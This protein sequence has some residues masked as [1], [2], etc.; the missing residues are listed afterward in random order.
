M[1]KILL[2]LILLFACTAIVAQGAASVDRVKNGFGTNLTACTTQQCVVIRQIA[3][4]DI[5][6]NGTFA[7]DASW[8]KG[9]NWSITGGTA[10]FASSNMVLNGTFANTNNWET[11]VYWC[12]TNSK[13][14]YIVG[15]NNTNTMFQIITEITSGKTYRL[16]YTLADLSGYTYVTPYV[17]SVAGT[18]Y[19]TNGLISETITALETST[20]LIF[21]GKVASPNLLANSTFANTN[22][23]ETN[24]WWIVTGGKAYYKSEDAMTNNISQVVT[25]TSGLTYKVWYTLADIDGVV[26]VNPVAGSSNWTARG[27]NGTYS[28][29]LSCEL[30][31]TTASTSFQ[32]RAWSDTA[33]TCSIDNVTF[34]VAPSG[35]GSVDNVFLREN[36][37]VETNDISQPSGYLSNG[38][39][40]RI[41]YTLAGMD[42]GTNTVTPVLGSS[43]GT[44]ATTNATY[45][46]DLT[47]FGS[48][49]N[50]IFRGICT[51]IGSCTLDN[52]S[53][54]KLPDEA[55]ANEIQLTTA[56]T[57]V[58]IYFLFNG[59]S[60]E[61]TN[62]YLDGTC[63]T[64]TS[65]QVSFVI[66]DAT[67]AKRVSRIWY[68]TGSGAATVILNAN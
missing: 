42:P 6:T 40:Y 39:V 59:S 14:F 58:P 33:A 22:S 10:V 43:V 49:S 45:T 34:C 11:N 30:A 54:K 56:A 24:A 12:T 21:Q 41:T 35:T 16:Q 47:M 18:T 15:D 46:E 60:P 19:G 31:G 3:G 28:E 64:L 62:A 57:A 5:V 4:A 38:V 27:T 68:R 65:N 17:G 7:S 8:T 23:W 9:T 66:D 32:F 53:I 51:N 50:I 63:M 29:T 44:P 67:G 36:G 26:F 37:W 1:R 20:N 25:L 48:A 55:Y 13:G 52:V 61:M 2:P